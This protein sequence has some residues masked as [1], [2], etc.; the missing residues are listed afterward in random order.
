[1]LL[2]IG[3]FL[4]ST[5][6]I[7]TI[8]NNVLIDL[9]WDK[10]NKWLKP[11]TYPLTLIA[12]RPTNWLRTGHSKRQRYR[13]QDKPKTLKTKN[14]KPKIQDCRLNFGDSKLKTQ[15]MI[16]DSRFKTVDSRQGWQLK[17]S[18]SSLETK[19]LKLKTQDWKLKI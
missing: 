18:N 5:R 13:T 1:M 15:H 17:T 16:G 9:F 11:F 12:T 4:I 2:M 10:L 8:K 14:S 6:I 3:K 19:P 7:I